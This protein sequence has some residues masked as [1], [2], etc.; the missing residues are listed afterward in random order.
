MDVFCSTIIPTINRSTLPQAVQSVLDQSFNEA[1]FEIIV[2][3][4]SG[5]PLPDAGWQHCDQVRVIDTNRR[6][7]SVARNTGAAIAEGEYLHFLD[8]DDILLP[9]AFQAY[10]S[11]AK[12]SSADW[13]YGGWQT[14]DND[15][16]LVDEFRP[17]LRGN[18]FA[19][20]VSGESI[21]LQASLIKTKSFFASGAFDPMITGVEDRDLGRRI[22]L[23]GDIAY[24]PGVVARVRIGEQGSTTD[25][26]RL[27]ED[28]RWGREKALSSQKSFARLWD[29]IQS[30]YWRGRVCRAYFASCVWNLKRLNILTALSRG[31]AG[32]ILVGSGVI[33]PNFWSGLREK[34]K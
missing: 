32:L 27:A 9:G 24:C 28:D 4:D 7:R 6:E 34:I 26:A 11:V 18:I 2:V 23:F 31:M 15:G 19:L 3:N 5:V 12:D 17:E 33:K 30:G 13:L 1:G 10:W 22:A 29:S 16:K 14:V 20:V 25:W 21:P 8:D